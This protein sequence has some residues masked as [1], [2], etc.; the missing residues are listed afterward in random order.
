MPPDQ[1]PKSSA[2]PPAPSFKNDILPMF[3]QVDI[4][5]M[6]PMGVLLNDYTYMSTP[7]NAHSVY[8]Y[9]TGSS[10]P[11]MPIGGPY[12]T[13]AQLAVFDR[14]MTTGYKP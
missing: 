12:W 13:A 6:R 7:A 10:Q 2:Q 1:N 14:W 8:S 3:R 5:H 9:L 4:D 11:Q